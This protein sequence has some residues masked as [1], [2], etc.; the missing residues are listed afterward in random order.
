[1]D[2]QD[3]PGVLQERLGVEASGGLVQLFNDAQMEWSGQVL[4]LAA[5]RFERRLVEETSKLRVE[6]A[7]GFAAVRGEMAAQGAQLRV[8]MAQGFAAARGEM[9]TQGAT[10]NDKIDSVRFDLVKWMFL[11]WIGQVGAVVALMALMR[12]R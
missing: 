5:E 4:N 10:L 12:G 7:Q 9:A 6:M 8:E 1:M 2:L 3:V 11:F